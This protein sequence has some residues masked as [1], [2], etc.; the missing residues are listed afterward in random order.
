MSAYLRAQEKFCNI[1][2][3]EPSKFQIFGFDSF[4]G[5]P[6]SK[7]LED[8]HPLWK[9]NEFSHD[10]EEVKKKISNGGLDLNK[11]NIKFMA[12]FIN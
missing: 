10:I 1:T 6:E 12:N 8:Q 2:K 7:H 11:F 9:K 3:T 5:L 4:E